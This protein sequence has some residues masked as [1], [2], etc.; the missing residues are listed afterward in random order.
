MKNLG[1]WVFQVQEVADLYFWL[2]AISSHAICG[3]KNKP[4]KPLTK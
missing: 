2:D 4:T 1:A 3:Y